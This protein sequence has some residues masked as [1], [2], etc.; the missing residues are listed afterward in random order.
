MNLVRKPVCSLHVIVDHGSIR[1]VSG[2]VGNSK[3]I[4]F[5]IHHFLVR[6]M[7]K[8]PLLTGIRLDRIANENCRM[9]VRGVHVGALAWPEQSP[10][11]TL[12]HHK[13]R[14]WFI[15][16]MTW[17]RFRSGGRSTSLPP[18]YT[19]VSCYT[20]DRSRHSPKALGEG[21]HR[22]NSVAGTSGRECYQPPSVRAPPFSGPE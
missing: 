22:I 19:H 2:E 21:R 9:V 11:W 7:G 16:V 18:I 6:R 10:S 8:R 17:W 4:P 13:L 20:V 5:M 3:E 12:W 15:T 1:T 14:R